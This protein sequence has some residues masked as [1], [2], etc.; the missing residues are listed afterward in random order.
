MIRPPSPLA[1]IP[2]A[3]ML[4]HPQPRTAFA[5]GL[6]E[7]HVA[8][9]GASTAS[10]NGTAIPPF[11]LALTNHTLSNGSVFWQ[12]TE[13]PPNGPIWCGGI[14][15]GSLWCDWSCRVGWYDRWSYPPP[16][17]GHGEPIGYTT[18]LSG[19]GLDDEPVNVSRDGDGF[20]IRIGSAPSLLPAETVQ[21]LLEYL[22]AWFAG[23][24][25]ETPV[26]YIVRYFDR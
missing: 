1:L 15:D 11:R 24:T 26:E 22:Q 20:F 21:D 2:A 25:T 4:L 16:A 23:L 8:A 5:D 12:I 6:A 17:L 13:A 19:Y 9:S 18:V 10:V 3:L 7:V 14:T